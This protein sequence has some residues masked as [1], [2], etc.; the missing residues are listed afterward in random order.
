MTFPTATAVS[1]AAAL[2]AG[3]W[4]HGSGDSPGA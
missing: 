1:F 3:W 4:R 2:R